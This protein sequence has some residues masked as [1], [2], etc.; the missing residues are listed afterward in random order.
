M[1]EDHANVAL[2][3]R[4]DLRNL[5]A[6]AKLFAPDFVWHYVNPNLPDLEGDYVGVDGLRTFFDRIGAK[7]GG[8]F[9]VEPVSATAFGDELLVAH[10]RNSLCLQDRTIAIH[11]IVVW[12][13]VNGRLAEAWDIPSAYTTAGPA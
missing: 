5:A 6:S 12:R 2:L 4:L 1:T 10:V 11:A 7:T 13:V 8:S 9:K 3:K